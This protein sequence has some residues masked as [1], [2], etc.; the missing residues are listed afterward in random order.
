M[1]DEWQHEPSWRW[2]IERIEFFGVHGAPWS[3][4]PNPEAI[5]S[6]NFGSV[7]R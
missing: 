4:L 6:A 2:G 5:W 3:W 7:Q 1:K